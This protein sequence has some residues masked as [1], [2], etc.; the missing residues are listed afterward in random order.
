MT[1]AVAVAVACGRRVDV[2]IGPCPTA[3]APATAPAAMPGNRVRVAADW[4]LG[5]A[6]PRKAVQPGP[7]RSSSMPLNTAS[8]ELAR[9][10]SA[11]PHSA[12]DRHAQ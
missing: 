7:V 9:S 5:A 6:L 10:R 3:T 2:R 11:T 1:V 8:P 4:L 12:D